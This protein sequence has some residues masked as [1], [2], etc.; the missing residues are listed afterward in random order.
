MEESNE[1][2]LSLHFNAQ[3]ESN[4]FLSY[5]N[6]DKFLKKDFLAINP[7]Y[8]VN[9]DSHSKL[10]N[11]DLDKANYFNLIE[12]I[13]IYHLEN[14][15]ANEEEEN[16]SNSQ[17]NNLIIE[18]ENRNNNSAK[19]ET[20]LIS[21]E[22]ISE[23]N[24]NKGKKLLGRKKNGEKVNE[25]EG[26][27]HNMYSNDN[28]S[29]KIQTHFLNFIIQSLNCIFSHCNY[30][31]KLYKF[32]YEF[33][34]NIKKKNFVSLND[35]N[36]GDIISN[37]KI[38]EKYTSIND[39]YEANKIICEK[40][41]DIP[42][43]IKILSENYLV[44]FKKFYYCRDSYINL[45]DYGLDKDIVFTKDVKNFK[46]FLNENEKRGSQYI[47]SIKK[48]VLKKYLPGSIFICE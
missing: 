5:S 26:S 4:E 44:F 10:F 37:H 39:K 30:N 18:I 31:K 16:A 29:V 45:N 8:I 11:I 17:I 46:H 42:V 12:N 21:Q 28:I 22:N 13:P 3:L 23:N 20:P 48:H 6:Y 40:I 43:L 7:G 1:E 9:I 25:P 2:S 24:S 38:S 19:I 41:K 15:D 36:I 47:K 33:K 14:Y 27:S 34:K 32:D 35:E